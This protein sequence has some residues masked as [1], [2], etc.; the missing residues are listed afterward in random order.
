MR[1]QR[2]RGRGGGRRELANGLPKWLI[3]G[4]AALF[5]AWNG[6]LL[7]QYA[8]WCSPERQGLDWARVIQGQVEMP[9]KAFGLIRDFLFDRERFYRST[10]NCT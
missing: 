4:V 9:G 2:W 5:V 10:R 3:A 6:G 8:L 7:M 1:T